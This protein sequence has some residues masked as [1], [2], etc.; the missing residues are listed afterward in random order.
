MKLA[1]ARILLT[2]A[3]GGIGRCLALELAR[4]GARLALLAR[5]PSR[6]EP[7]AQAV[8]AVGGSALCVPFDL[9]RRDGHT[10]VVAR[11][12]SELGGLDAL[13]NN[14]G[15]SRFAGYADDAPEAICNL[16]DTNLTGALLLTRAVLPHFVR[17]R[18]GHIVNVG[19]IFGSIAFPYFAAYS[20]SKFALRGFSEA[21]RRE[22]AATGVRVTYVAPRT[23]ATSMNSD[24]VLELFSASKTAMD[25][26]EQVAAHIVAAVARDRKDVYLGWPERF[27]ARL[28]S[29]LPRLVDGALSRQARL[30]DRLLHPRTGV[31]SVRRTS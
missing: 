26:P 1:G 4:R 17:R 28:N 18:A 8:H 21:L 5:D 12:N 14:A 6:L 29:V 27:F 20:A 19:S 22:L 31:E 7:V 9:V 2:G 24:A 13:V 23:T 16:I 30:A 3:S 11:V 10:S 25:R 15:V